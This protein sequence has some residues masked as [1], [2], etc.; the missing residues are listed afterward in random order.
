MFPQIAPLLPKRGFFLAFEKWEDCAC[1]RAKS[2]D[3]WPAMTQRTWYGEQPLCE[4]TSP[5][6][7]KRCRNPDSILISRF[8]ESFCLCG[9]CALRLYVRDHARDDTEDSE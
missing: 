8:G 2:R 4:E 6:T 7:G 9:E 3:S 5:A 1:D